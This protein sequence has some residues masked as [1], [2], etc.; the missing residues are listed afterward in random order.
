MAKESS[1]AM[2][3]KVR[4]VH[5]NFQKD[6]RAFLAAPPSLYDPSCWNAASQKPSSPKEKHV[7]MIPWPILRL[8]FWPSL[9]KIGWKCFDGF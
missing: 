3:L 9:S 2:E 4:L 6:I 1:S 8:M 5:S 7:F